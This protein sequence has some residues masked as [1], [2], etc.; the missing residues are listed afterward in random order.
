[1]VLG[2]SRGVSWRF[3]VA[4]KGSGTDAR[5]AGMHQICTEDAPKGHQA[6]PIHEKVDEIYKQIPQAM[7]DKPN[8]YTSTC[9][10]G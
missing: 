3:V 5:G 7:G 4:K 2:G 1:M 10:G 8:T 6:G 9:C